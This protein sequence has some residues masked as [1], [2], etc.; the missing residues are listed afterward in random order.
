MTRPPIP[1]N[2][3]A[4]STSTPPPGFGAGTTRFLALAIALLA[5]PTHQAH[6]ATETQVAQKY[7]IE[8]CRDANADGIDDF[9]DDGLPES[10]VDL[11]V[12]FDGDGWDPTFAATRVAQIVQQ[13]QAGVTVDYVSSHSPYVFLGHVFLDDP[14]SDTPLLQALL[15]LDDVEGIRPYE[16]FL[17]N[18][19]LKG[20]L[21]DGRGRRFAEDASGPGAGEGRP[22]S[23]GSDILPVPPGDLPGTTRQ[24]AEDAPVLP[25]VAAIGVLVYMVDSGIDAPTA[26]GIDVD[27]DDPAAPAL[28]EDPDDISAMKH[29]SYL[30][31][32]ARRVI[33]YGQWPGGGE[34]VE[35]ADVRVAVAPGG[36]TTTLELTKAFDAIVQHVAWRRALGDQARIVVNVSYDTDGGIANHDIIYPA[37]ETRD[38]LDPRT[39]L[40]SAPSTP[41]SI[42]GLGLPVPKD[43][44]AG[45]LFDDVYR[46]L[47][48]T[49]GALVSVGAGN[50]GAAAA[51]VLN[52]M[53][54]SAHATI[55]TSAY[56]A[57]TKQ[58]E[59][60]SNYA[61]APN[62]KNGHP[63]L[64]AAGSGYAPGFGYK[65]E[66][67][68][69]ATAHVSAVAAVRLSQA[70]GL[71]PSGVLADLIE[72]GTPIS[73]IGNRYYGKALLRL[74]NQPVYETTPANPP[75]ETEI[76]AVDFDAR[77]NPARP[78]AVLR[79]RLET[80]GPAHVAL[81][82]VA[83]RRVRALLDA[84]L[85]PGRHEV[86]FD[87]RNDAGAPVA[88]GLYFARI[89]TRGGTETLRLLVHGR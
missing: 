6:A 46:T 26:W 89:A 3:S 41:P 32:L 63:N 10:S 8:P 77:P 38:R 22:A 2:S 75:T 62:G 59:P 36:E 48:Q 88:T 58:P 52:E 25:D 34:P 9:F 5:L 44:C 57:R 19:Q 53:G 78:A 54:Q 72:D 84:E 31:A 18:T 50:D 14:P 20:G 16:R 23:P 74:P 85:P 33:E 65:L 87:G 39:E 11:M 24:L 64:A 12:L 17:L 73:P 4:F 61:P 15:A 40:R 71:S 35:F 83:G 13:H 1:R 21:G 7:Y 43:P 76:G 55:V 60:Y 66:G 29:G 51:F 80:A 70:A 28:A 47:S 79:F 45:H 30:H 42:R 86:A 49:Y 82:D 56:D 27:V 81:Y 37:P 69:V 67:T 68:S